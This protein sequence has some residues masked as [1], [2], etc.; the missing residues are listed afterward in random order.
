MLPPLRS[1]AK[2]VSSASIAEASD[3][4]FQEWIASHN[5][6][7]DDDGIV[8]WSFDDRLDVIC[9]A[10]ENGLSLTFVDASGKPYK[11][12]K[13]SRP[14]E[15]QTIEQTITKELQNNSDISLNAQLFEPAKEAPARGLPTGMPDTSG[16]PATRAVKF[17]IELWNA[18]MIDNENRL[19]KEEA[20]KAMED[21]QECERCGVEATL[22][23]MQTVPEVQPYQEA[24]LCESCVH[25]VQVGDT[26]WKVAK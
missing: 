10:L 17:G 2:S 18:A 13:L 3:N 24:M 21:T 4:H 23:K 5:V 16:T 20:T 14:A 9:Y 8:E 26:A 22:I 19:K 25:D 6:P 11:L 15:A 1:E 12:A 7:V